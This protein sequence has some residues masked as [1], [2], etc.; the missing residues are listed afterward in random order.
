MKTIWFATILLLMSI[1]NSF[2][3]DTVRVMYYNIL[4]FPGDSPERITYLRKILLYSKPDV[5]VVNELLSEAGSNAILTEALNVF[6]ETKYA[7]A[8]YVNGYDTDNMLFYN[9][10]VLGLISQGEIPTGLR[11]INE[12]ILYYKSPGLNSASDTVKLS[13]Y[14]LHLKAGSGFFDQ[15]KEEAL[16]LKNHLNANPARENIFAGGDFNFYSGNESGCIAMREGGSRILVDPIDQIGN[17]NNNASYA[18]VHTQSTRSSAL[19]DGAGGGMDDRFDL[20]FISEDVLNNSNGITYLAESYSALG[21]DGER[22]NE[23]IN[24]PYNTSIPDSISQALYYMSDHLPVMLAVKLDY[25][26][27]LES[28]I[29]DSYNA[30]LNPLTKTLTFNQDVVEGDFKLYDLNGRI[31]HHEKLNNS[32]SLQLPTHLKGG[33]YIWQIITAQAISSNKFYLP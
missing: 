26:A 15:R 2:G 11:D 33:L 6:G 19:S 24:S 13:F 22:F 32:H 17:W 29:K 31:I 14:S 23:A 18:R 28:L 16:K 27:S 9:T 5:F 12:Y 3:Q 30:Y 25:T 7:A 4:N 20:I 1:V 8:T 21:Q 10:D